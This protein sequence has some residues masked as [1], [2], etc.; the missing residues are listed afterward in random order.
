MNAWSF[1]MLRKAYCKKI[2]IIALFEAHYLSYLKHHQLFPIHSW[3]DRH[4]TRKYLFKFCWS[5]A[6]ILT[7]QSCLSIVYHKCRTFLPDFTPIPEKK[8]WKLILFSAH[9][10]Y[11]IYLGCVVGQYPFLLTFSS[12]Q[13]EALGNV[14]NFSKLLFTYSLEICCFCKKHRWHCH[15]LAQ[16]YSR[17]RGY[18]E[19][20][21]SENRPQWY[22]EALPAM[23][24]KTKHNTKVS[25]DLT[26]N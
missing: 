2:N 18:S 19:H 8:N 13:D 10:E 12:I 4:K 5:K 24:M 22:L 1:W 23:R 7:Y 11:K 9:S 15:P 26:Q 17:V 20:P 25:S 3:N 21:F 16:D 6:W 14:A